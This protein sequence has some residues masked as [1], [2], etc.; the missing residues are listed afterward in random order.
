MTAFV[1]DSHIQGAF[2]PASP[3]NPGTAAG[4][5]AA[6][7]TAACPAGPEDKNS[8]YSHFQS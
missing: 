5:D 7:S 2:P 6:P 3:A 8:K 4:G 1:T